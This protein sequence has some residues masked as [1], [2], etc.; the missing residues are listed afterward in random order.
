MTTVSRSL[1]QEF[2]Y[3]DGLQLPPVNNAVVPKNSLVIAKMPKS[4]YN[5]NSFGGSPEFRVV[6]MQNDTLMKQH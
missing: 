4:S 6:G 2:D 5:A 1:K 3:Q